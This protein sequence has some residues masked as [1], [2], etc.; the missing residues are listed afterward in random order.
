MPRPSPFPTLVRFAAIVLLVLIFVQVLPALLSVTGMTTPRA[1]QAASPSAD[2]YA[3]PAGINAAGLW[4]MLK[5]VFAVALIGFLGRIWFLLERI[6]ARLERNKL[7]VNL[8][9]KKDF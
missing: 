4:E 7:D 6:S 3:A 8:T 1:P 9:M 2:Y 5:P